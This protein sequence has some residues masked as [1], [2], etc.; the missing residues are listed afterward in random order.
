MRLRIDSEG[1]VP[2]YVQVQEQIRALVAAGQLQPGEQLPTIRALAAQLN[3]NYNTIARAYLELD[4]AGVVSTQRGRGTFVAGVQDETQ[5]TIRRQ[6]K[7]D[8]IVEAAIAEARRLGY[9]PGEFA[10][11]LVKSLSRWREDVGGGAQ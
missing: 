3:V 2:I 10:A 8:R 11:A 4:R 6:R 5:G 1:R 9:S 7:L